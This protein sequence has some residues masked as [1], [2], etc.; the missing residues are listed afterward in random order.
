[1]KIHVKLFGVFGAAART[2]EL[3]LT[4]S[5]DKPTVKS[6]IEAL[7]SDDSFADLRQLLLDPKTLDARP[8][9][10]I[11]VSGREV[12][13]LNGLGTTLTPGD[14]VALLPVAHGG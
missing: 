3:D 7:V 9:A 13:T 4:V 12:S 11:M 2:R 8:N 6:V 1:M 14:E 10:L 5:D